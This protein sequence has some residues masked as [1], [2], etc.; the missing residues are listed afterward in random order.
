MSNIVS[1]LILKTGL[2]GTGI[3]SAENTLKGLSH[4][5]MSTK[6]LITGAFAA[7]SSSAAVIGLERAFNVGSEMQILSNATGGAVK[8]LVVLRKAFEENGIDG[9]KLGETM[10]KLRKN[11]VQAAATGSGEQ[12][13]KLGLSVR[14]LGKMSASD[15]LRTI[16]AA[17]MQIQNP[18]ERSAYAMQLF[19]R[20]GQQMLALFAN[21]DAIGDA[22]TLLGNQA[23]LLDENSAIFSDITS[24]LH[25]VGSK[26]QGFFVGMAARIA[27]VLKP[28]LDGFAKMD[29]S[30]M[31]EQIGD[32]IAFIVTAF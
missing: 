16:G 12:F 23:K 24:K 28:L 30:G 7:I 8:D 5:V 26:M 29:F 1:E 19:G 9:D 21:G 13:R 2:F 15:Q 6:G 4:T 3:K 11:I 18:T 25:S 17:I 10:G 14:E 27:P 20:S 32:V 31:G 22:A